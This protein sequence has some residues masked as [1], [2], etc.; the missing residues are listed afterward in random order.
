MVVSERGR[1]MSICGASASPKVFVCE[2]VCVWSSGVCY[3]LEGNCM[4]SSENRRVGVVEKNYVFIQNAVYTHACAHERIHTHT[5]AHSLL[6]FGHV[7]AHTQRVRALALRSSS[8]CTT[9]LHIWRNRVF[10]YG[11][12]CAPQ[13]H[14]VLAQR[15]MLFVRRTHWRTA[16]FQARNPIRR[17]DRCCAFCLS[18]RSI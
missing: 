12:T 6:P 18:V 9:L 8:H 7:V 14:R 4:R 11:S 2:C 10:R 1:F 13:M 15:T 5:L 17:A 16:R 3:A